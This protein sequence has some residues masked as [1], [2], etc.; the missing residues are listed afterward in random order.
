[1]RETFIFWNH[2]EVTNGPQ[3]QILAMSKGFGGPRDLDV[4]PE[5]LSAFLKDHTTEGVYL[6][7]ALE[8][9]GFDIFR[10]IRE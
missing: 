4:L 7:Y 2:A 6:Q 10:M 1:M 3:M 9:E 5:P 8:P